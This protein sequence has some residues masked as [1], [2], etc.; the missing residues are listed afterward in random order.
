MLA[1]SAMRTGARPVAAALLA[2]PLVLVVLHGGGSQPTA[3]VPVATVVVLAVVALAAAAAFGRLPAGGPP[4][5][6]G[7][8]LV[9]LAVAYVAWGGLSTVWSIGPDRSWAWLNRGLVYLG[10]LALGLLAAA[11]L[12]RA[13]SVLASV[14]AAV[15]GVALVWA[16][17]GEA[18]P[19]LGPDVERSARLRE[20][21]GYW[22]ALA[23]VFAMC[24]PLALRFAADRERRAWARAVPTSALA[25]AL[26]GVVLTGSRGGVLVAFVAATVWLAL[27]PERRAGILALAVALPVAGAVAAVALALPGVTETGAALAERRQDGALFGLALAAGLAAAFGGAYA[28]ARRRVALDGVSGR[29]LVAVSLALVATAIAAGGVAARSSVDGF[30]NPPDRQVTQDVGRILETS[31]NNRCTWWREAGQLFAGDPLG[32]T[33]AGTYELARRPLREDT[34]HPLSPHDLPLQALAETGLVGFVLLAGVIAAAA[35]VVVAALRRAG[36]ERPAVVALAA[37]VSAWAAHALV[38]MSWE[39]PAV[40]APVFATLGVL[41]AR[42]AHGHGA[43]RRLGPLTAFALAALGVA[44]LSSVV[45]PWLAERRLDDASA[46]IAAGDLVAAASA[47]DDAR[48]LDPLSI[49]PIQLRAA[50]AEAGGDERRALRLYREAVDLQPRNPDT[51]FELGRHYLVARRDPATAFCALDRAYAIDSW[52][53]GTNDLLKEVRRALRGRSV[54]CRFGA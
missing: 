3:L 38:D 50:I 21:V 28:L 26:V 49:D 40:T 23:L 27:A 41:A 34:Q 15:T 39:Y 33:G 48:S 25:G 8:V 12:P 37:V 17:A 36:P 54:E 6:S 43:G 52:D 30:C 32:G 14:L 11:V 16:L 31:F 51:W 13:A 46:A 2:A 53:P 22:N 19:A 42:P 45:V 47:A 29:T 10:F 20:P 44:A 35:W 7:R 4:A 5:L 1:S 24:V 9:G 18:V